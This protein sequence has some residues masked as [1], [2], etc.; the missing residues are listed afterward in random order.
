MVITKESHE[1]WTIRQIDNGS[2]VV[3][4]NGDKQEAPAATHLLFSQ[5]VESDAVSLDDSAESSFESE[6]DPDREISHERTTY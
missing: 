5:C 4:G 2:D 3:A 6:I 1:V